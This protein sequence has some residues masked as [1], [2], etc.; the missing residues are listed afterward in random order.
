MHPEQQYLDLLQKILDEGV[1][2]VNGTDIQDR[3]Y[4]PGKTEMDTYS[5]FGTQMRFDLQKGFPLLTTKKVYHRAIVH[6]L[7]WLLSGSS[8]IEYLKENKVKIWDEWAD[9]NGELGRVYGVQWRKWMKPDGTTVDQIQ[10]V[11]D[12]IKANPQSRRLIVSAWN[13]G[14]IEKMN[15]PPCHMTFQFGVFNGRLNCHL[16]Q[17]SGDMFLG[18]PFNIASYSFLTHMMA[19]QTGLEPGELVHTIVDAHIYG[20]HMDAVKEQL[21]RVPKDFPTLKLNKAKSIF[22]Y[23]FEDFEIVDY[24]PHPRIKAPITL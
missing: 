20:D 4:V 6:E 8:N 17:R 14:E 5:V 10:N 23:K 9:E 7:L 13:P 1:E 15:L 3:A 18:V 24:D 22:D 19:Q 16:L 2:R 11:V 21:S 12:K